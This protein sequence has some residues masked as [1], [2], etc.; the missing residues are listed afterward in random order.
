MGITAKDMARARQLNTLLLQHDSGSVERFVRAEVPHGLLGDE[1]L[2]AARAVNVIPAVVC[3]ATLGAANLPA[4]NDRATWLAVYQSLSAGHETP[5]FAAL[6]E[7]LPLKWVARAVLSEAPLDTLAARRSSAHKGGLGEWLAGCE[8]AVDRRRLDLVEALV[9]A[10]LARKT[11]LQDWVQIAQCLCA[12]EDQLHEVWNSVA[13]GRAFAR[14]RAQLPAKALFTDVRSL[15]AVRAA[16]FYL[17]G[18]DNEKALAL[19]KRGS[20]CTDIE[21]RLTT[22]AQAHCR[23]GDLAA[24][25]ADLDDYMQWMITPSQLAVLSRVNAQAHTTEHPAASFDVDAASRALTDLQGVL[26]ARGQKAFLVS[27]TLLGYAREGQLLA[28]DKDL[29]VGILHWE[30]QY[31]IAAALLKSKLFWVRVP[32]IGDSQSYYVPI[33]HLPTKVTTDI[34]IYHRTG[35]QLVTA[36]PHFFGHTQ[37]FAFSGFDLRPVEFLG[38]RVYVPDDVERNLRENFGPGWR[39]PDPD[40]LS[41]LEAPATVDAGGLAYQ[42]TGRLLLARYLRSAKLGK[43][44]RALSALQRHQARPGGMAPTLLRRFA[45]LCDE[46]AQAPPV[47]AVA[48]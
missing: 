20:S 5:E 19:A 8:L 23:A 43:A 46:L 45:G 30:S 13:L 41:H 6:P 15:L 11:S 18:G 48:S 4:P 24:C 36:T 37:K 2:D 10:R 14:I 34:F 44:R 3:L 16:K 42:I 27:G 28:H 32:S 9:D 25:I 21:M 17:E 40:F 33:M 7:S 29:D 38:T 47:A 26:D 35:D 39:V 12:R 22:I 31:D 1:M